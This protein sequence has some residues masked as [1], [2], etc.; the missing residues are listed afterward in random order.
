LTFALDAGGHPVGGIDKG[1]WEG[2]EVG[3]VNVFAEVLLEAARAWVD[4]S[5]VPRPALPGRPL[6]RGKSAWLATDDIDPAEL[7]SEDVDP[8]EFG[9]EVLEYGCK[10]LDGGRRDREHCR[11][12]RGI[13]RWSRPATRLM[14]F[15]ASAPCP[16]QPAAERH[17]RPLAEFV[18][19]RSPCN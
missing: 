6:R 14:A 8:E 15:P 19:R 1:P 7:T 16:R 10:D 13:R 11:Y 9:L 5:R 18:R 4:W 12:S 2:W 3:G 17:V